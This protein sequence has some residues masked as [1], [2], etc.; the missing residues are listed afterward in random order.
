[1]DEGIPLILE[2]RLKDARLRTAQV[3]KTSTSLIDRVRA[4]VY[5]I[6]PAPKQ[7]EHNTA[8]PHSTAILQ[9]WYAPR[10]DYERTEDEIRVRY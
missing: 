7:P 4:V 1:M 2:Q 8:G 6:I 10:P 3:F 5:W 9:Q